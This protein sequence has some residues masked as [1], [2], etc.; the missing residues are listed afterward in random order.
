MSRPED[1]TGGQIT[2]PI[3][4]RTMAY[5]RLVRLGWIDYSRAEFAL[6]RPHAGDSYERI[7][8]A[9]DDAAKRLG[10][11][12]DVLDARDMAAEGRDP[13]AWLQRQHRRRGNYPRLRP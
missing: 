8:Q 13:A 10:H 1:A 3:D 12:F 2:P 5:A 11:A 7:D 4:R 6:A 9:L